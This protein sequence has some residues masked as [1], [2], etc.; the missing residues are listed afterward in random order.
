MRHRLDPLL[1]PRSIAVLGATRREGSVGSRAI[2]NLLKGGFRGA[3]YAVNPAYDEVQGVACY[4]SLEELPGPVEHVIFAVSDRRMD[5][6]MEQ[7]IAHGARAAT[8]MSNLLLEDDTSPPLKQRIAA[9]A[10]EAGLLLCGGNCMGFYNF[11]DHV[12][13]CGFATRDHRPPGNVSYISQSGS[14][15]CGIV[16]VDDRIDFNLVVTSGHEITVGV[17]DY[18]DFALEQP[19]TRVVGLFLETVRKPAQLVCALAKAVERGIPVVAVKVGRTALS[20]QLSVSHS[21]GLAGDDAAFEALFDRYGV[22]RVMDTDELATAMIMFAQPYAVADG[23]LVSIHDSGGERQLTIDL[24]EH[25]GVPLTRVTDATVMELQCW[26]E[27]GLPAVNPLDAWSQGGPDYDDI[28]RN[29]FAA[30]ASDPG[31]ALAAV[32]H[33]R[34]AGSRIV[35]EYLGYMQAAHRASGKP[36]FLVAPRQGTGSDPR[37]VE[38]TRLGFPVLDGLQG[39]LRGVYCMLGYRD[40]CRRESAV[41]EPA[42]PDLVERW[43]RRLAQ[44]PELGEAET[45]R[46]LGEFGVP[47]N[48]CVAASDEQGACLAAAGMDK[49]VVL[50]TAQTGVAH[51]SELAGVILNLQGPLEVREAYRDLAARL[52][53]RVVIA[54]MVDGSE[55]VEMILGMV[56]DP[57]FGPLVIVGIGGVQAELLNDRVVALAPVDATSCQ[58]ML[59]RLRLRALLDEHRGRRAVN[60]QLLCRA[61]ERFSVMVHALKDDLHEIEINPLIASPGHC[62]GVDALLVRRA[63]QENGRGIEDEH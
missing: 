53:P 33:D 50:K 47:M 63:G 32:I 45:A 8:L 1:R 4:A 34:I 26:L 49:P 55:A 42:D 29:C 36:T 41:I 44:A 23:G 15:M 25:Y 19:E 30:L 20:A 14:A 12:W 39:F 17:E 13:A 62:V 59:G 11:R 37:V 51:K 46:M 58:R 10:R 7:V 28:M 54:P 22:Q 21:G 31:A 43:R 35:P 60:L 57:Q 40:F 9:R 27:P 61:V 16:D 24:A 6:A 56:R 18:L 48:P 38:Y 5:E 2:E 3:L 52:G